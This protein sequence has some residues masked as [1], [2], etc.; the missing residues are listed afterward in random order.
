M[1]TILVPTDFSPAAKNA[2]RYAMHIAKGL[3]A[4]VL[5]C[6]AILIPAEAPMAGTVI[7]PFEDYGSLKET[8][9]HELN[10]F[11][12][13]LKAHE[14]EFATSDGFRPQVNIGSGIGRV[15]DVVSEAFNTQKA[16][17]AIMGMANPGNL[18][19][20]FL[21]SNSKELIEAATFPL[22]LVPS[23]FA[24]AKITKIAIATDLSDGDIEVIHS[25]ASFARHFNAEILV[26]HITDGFYNEKASKKIIDDFLRQITNKANYPKI[27][28]RHVV[29]LDVNNGLEWLSEHGRVDMLAI[30]HRKHSVWHHIFQGSHSQKIA[31][32]INIPLMIYPPNCHPFL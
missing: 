13:N 31:K 2:A 29:D 14:W 27:Y 12:N 22:I 9:E 28:Y 18:S 10:R 6:N 20:F 26:V 5:L 1:K 24:F 7:W 16:A 21:G 25:I 23:D 15:V 17:F 8:A 19:R 11:A 32:Q 4:N 30:I 3:K